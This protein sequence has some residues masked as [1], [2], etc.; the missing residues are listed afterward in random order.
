MKLR[1]I[2]IALLLALAAW[3]PA[4]ARQAGAVPQAQAP[5]A[6]DDS[7]KSSDKSPCACC[8][9]RKDQKDTSTSKATCC[10]GKDM[11]CCKKDSKDTASAMK[12]CAGKDMKQCAAKDGKGCCGKDAKGCCGK[13]AMACN[14]KN[15][16][17]CCAGHSCMHGDA[18]S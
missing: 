1:M 4:M 15:G 12:C 5:V 13:N 7:A 10:D 11:A 6:Q 9:Q 16:K 3:L 17:H 14:S 2:A 18:Q 8:A